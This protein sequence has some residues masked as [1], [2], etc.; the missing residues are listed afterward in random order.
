M[1]QQLG[2]AK[3]IL[4]RERAYGMKPI[5]P[6]FAGYVPPSFT[7]V[8]PRSRVSQLEKWAQGFNGTFFLD[9]LDDMFQVHIIQY[10]LNFL[11]Y[12]ERIHFSTN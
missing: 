9:P 10:R 5:L 11:G 6:A 8:Y 3:L 4:Q 12:R 2:L 1:E 7:K